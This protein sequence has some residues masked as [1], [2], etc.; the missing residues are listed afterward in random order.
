MHGRNRIIVNLLEFP[1]LAVPFNLGSIV[2]RGGRM[3]AR[4]IGH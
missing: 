3:M 4:P 1:Q 2:E